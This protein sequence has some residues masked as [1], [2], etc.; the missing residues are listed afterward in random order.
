MPRFYLE[1][2]QGSRSK[3]FVWEPP[4]TSYDRPDCSGMPYRLGIRI[5]LGTPGGRGGGETP[6][7]AK[8][9]LRLRGSG[10]HVVTMTVARPKH[11]H[12]ARVE[13]YRVRLVGGHSVPVL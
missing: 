13:R 9:G 12:A 8:P 5:A 6:E 1:R 11:V 4:L 3:S 2:C 7:R 10:C